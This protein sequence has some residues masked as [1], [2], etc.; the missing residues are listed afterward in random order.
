MC[1]Q[2]LLLVDHLRTQLETSAYLTVGIAIVQQNSKVSQMIATAFCFF[3]I[4]HRF[5]S[6][7]SFPGPSVRAACKE[8]VNNVLRHLAIAYIH[9]RKK[10]RCNIF[11]F[12]PPSG[13]KVNFSLIAGQP[14]RLH[15]LTPFGHLEQTSVKQVISV[16]KQSTIEIFFFNLRLKLDLHLF[17]LPLQNTHSLAPS[18]TW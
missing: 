15:E 16:Q 6:M 10:K 14:R 17:S 1:Q 12:L 8:T 9:E 3:C 4:A 11:W 2:Q 18:A 13:E 5:H 7:T